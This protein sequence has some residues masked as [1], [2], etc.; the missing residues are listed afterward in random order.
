MG[1][2][3]T[4]AGTSKQF[5]WTK[6]MERI[7]LEILAEEAQKGNK[8]SNVFKPCSLHRVAAAISEKFNVTCESNHVE[9]HLKTVKST[10]LLISKIRGSS[11]F[12]WDENLKMIT[13]TKKVYDE[14][15]EKLEMYDEM[16]LVAGKD[17]ATGSFAKSFAD[18]D[19]DNINVVDQSMPIDLEPIVDEEVK[20]KTSSSVGTSNVRSHRKRKNTQEAGDQDVIRYMAD[21]LGEIANA[22]KL[23]VG[24]SYLDSL[25]EQ[26]MAMEGYSEDDLEAAYDYLMANQIEGKAFLRK[27]HNLRTRWLQRFFDGQV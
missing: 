26:V 18:I 6:P 10:W 27:S 13:A 8:P 9:N 15:L 14:A 22:I 21:Q 25:Y 3:K 20:G 7:L 24:E 19:L 12:G 2:G 16:A 5:R 4:E 23:M 1:K 17:M 11:E